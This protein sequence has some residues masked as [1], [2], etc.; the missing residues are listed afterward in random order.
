MN[1]SWTLHVRFRWLYR[2]ELLR[3]VQEFCYIFCFLDVS[4]TARETDDQPR[5]GLRR[6]RRPGR[7]SAQLDA[8]LWCWAPRPEVERCRPLVHLDAPWYPHLYVRHGIATT[9]CSSLYRQLF[10]QKSRWLFVFY[11]SV[12][13][14]NCLFFLL[15]ASRRR[16]SARSRGIS[17]DSWEMYEQ[18][19][20]GGV[21]VMA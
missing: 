6:K 12:I 7:H 13:F 20:F 5:L 9:F 16:K 4:G 21:R 14:C 17:C 3:T 2:F 18:E 10:R 8:H 11:M 1:A 19:M 15:S